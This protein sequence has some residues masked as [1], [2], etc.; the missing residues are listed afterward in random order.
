MNSNESNF[1]EER[2]ARIFKLINEYKRITVQEL[3][4][5]FKISAV[6]IRNDLNALE[7]AGK[8]IR[9]HGV[10]IATDE[11]LAESLMGGK[12]SKSADIN[13]TLGRVSAELVEDGE[14]I[15][16]D[17][18]NACTAIY[19]YLTAKNDLAV[20]T[21]SL[22]SGYW[23]A[24]TSST[25]VYL[26]GG[27]VRRDSLT[28]VRDMPDPVI[29]SWH[30]SKAFVSAYGFT[31]ADGL[32][33][34]SLSP[35]DQRISIIKRARQRIALIDSSKWG[36]ISMITVLPTAEIHMIITDRNAPSDMVKSLEDMGIEIILA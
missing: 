35:M 11:S 5:H 8:I 30:I 4:K 6:T 29:D 28:T 18:G 25:N 36:R 33:D 31:P 27:S 7:K 14:V 2:Q 22:E 26:L 1:L 3:S 32:M 24:K 23:L 17:G 10:A 13:R 21:P 34:V 15:F 20:I 16:I 12:L 19:P 9:T